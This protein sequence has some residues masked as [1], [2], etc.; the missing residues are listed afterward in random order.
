MRSH[1]A[2]RNYSSLQ[3]TTRCTFGHTECMRRRMRQSSP[4]A[5]AEDR[6]IVSADSDF[7]TILAAQEADH[8]SFILFREP[9]LL[10]APDYLNILLP[11]LLTLAPELAS[12]GVFRGVASVFVSCHFQGGSLR[13]RIMG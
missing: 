9:N 13:A 1:R 3:D 2:W 11:V 4:R 5:L 6:I 7:R 8:P 12:G 10:L